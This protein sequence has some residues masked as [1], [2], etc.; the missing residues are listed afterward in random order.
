MATIQISESEAERDFAGMMARVRGGSEFAIECDS[1]VVAVVR[2]P[3][4]E[5]RPRLVSELIAEEK[6]LE[7]DGGEIPVMDEEFAEDLAEIVRARKPW[8]PPVWE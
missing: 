1:K 3:E 8:N 4:E 6:M 2:P 5:F 7:A